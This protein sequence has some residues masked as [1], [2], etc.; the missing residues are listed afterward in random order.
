MRISKPGRDSHTFM[1]A[2]QPIARRK[3]V[4]P[5]KV[6]HFVNGSLILRNSQLMFELATS[7]NFHAVLLLFDLLL[8][9]IVKRV[10]AACVG[11]HVREGNLLSCPLLEK[12]LAARGMENEGRERSMEKTFFNILH[13]MAWHISHFRKDTQRLA[14]T[15]R[16]SMQPPTGFLIKWHQAVC[17]SHRQQ[18]NVRP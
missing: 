12:Q 5:C 1:F 18:C 3:V 10:R 8:L 11:P 4:Y 9:E 7:G 6:L 13:Q 16:C 17:R 15:K 14:S 2:P